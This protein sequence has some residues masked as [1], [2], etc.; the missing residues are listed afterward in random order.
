MKSD[1]IKIGIPIINGTNLYPMVKNEY[2]KI[3]PIKTI[4]KDGVEIWDISFTTL[5]CTYI[6][7]VRHIS[8]QGPFPLDV[9]SKRK[10][11]DI[12]R[13]VVVQLKTNDGDEIS[14][15]DLDPY[16][17]K[18]NK[19]DALIVNA[20]NYT[21]RW[22]DKCKG[23][24][25]IDGYNLNSPYFS[26]SAMQGIIDAGVSILAGNFP[27]FS[28]PKTEEGFGID[29]I[30]EFYKNQNNMI[31]APLINLDRIEDIK[32]ILQINP[33]LINNCCGIPCCPIVYQGKLKS[34]FIEEIL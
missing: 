23:I 29:M 30:A 16:L 28:N 14:L 9:F 32:V 27:S 24:I 12:Y 3:S 21:D 8:S 19:G 17:N 4:A 20:N 10:S 34:L 22:L 13:A 1:I 6:E 18:V 11:Y 31:L 33:I 2:T 26:T 15:S 5:D 7:T 25:N